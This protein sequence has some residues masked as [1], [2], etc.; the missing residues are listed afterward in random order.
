MLLTDL[1]DPEAK[2]LEWSTPATVSL[3]GV[4][5]GLEFAMAMSSMKRGG[6]FSWIFSFLSA[7]MARSIGAASSC[8]S[9]P[10]CMSDMMATK[11]PR[12][13]RARSLCV[14]SPMIPSSSAQLKLRCTAAHDCRAYGVIFCRP[15]KPS[16]VLTRLSMQVCLKA[17]ESS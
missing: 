4:K 15:R 2:M 16:T 6:R 5:E 13:R 14:C 11:R 8:G 17:L 10:V 12:S 7:E 9:S 3:C 1:P